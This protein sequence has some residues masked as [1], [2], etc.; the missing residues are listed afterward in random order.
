MGSDDHTTVVGGEELLNNVFAVHHDVALLQWV[1]LYI[2]MHTSHVI[3][4][5]WVT[6]EEVHSHLLHS[7]SD[8]SKCDLEWSLDLLN[9]FNLV[10][11]VTDSTV[12]T[13]DLVVGLLVIY[14]GSKWHVLKDIVELVEKTVGVIDVLVEPLG[15]LLTESK[16]SVHISVLVVTSEKEDLSWVLELESQEQAD[17]FKTL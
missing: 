16:V 14:H 17:H 1:S 9:V 8:A 3:C 15:A 4:W 11:T 7:V 6:P 5:A 12:D 10:D 2:C 13:E